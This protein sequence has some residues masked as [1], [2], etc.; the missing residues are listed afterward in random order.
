MIRDERAAVAAVA[1]DDPSFGVLCDRS[2]NS[3]LELVI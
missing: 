3:F 2:R 1:V